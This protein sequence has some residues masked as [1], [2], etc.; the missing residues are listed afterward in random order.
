MGYVDA[1]RACQAY[2]DA[3]LDKELTL[4]SIA[5]ALNFSTIYLRRSFQAVSNVT[6]GKYIQNAR[7]SRA[8]HDLIHGLCIVSEAARLSG[9]SSVFS[10][11]KTFNFSIVRN[12]CNFRFRGLPKEFRCLVLSLFRIITNSKSVSLSDF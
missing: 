8:A 5:K 6:V 11:S 10:F 1:A 7:L 2:I 12:A 9:Y 3:N 4:E